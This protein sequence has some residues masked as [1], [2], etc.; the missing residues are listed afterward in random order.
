MPKTAR[1]RLCPFWITVDGT[2]TPVCKAM[3]NLAAQA[4]PIE[5]SDR[6]EKYKADEFDWDPRSG[7]ILTFTAFKLRDDQL[8]SAC[9]EKANRSAPIRGDESL[10]E[11]VVIAYCPKHGL[12]VVP[13]NHI[14]PRHTVIR[15]LLGRVGTEGPVFVE[16]LIDTEMLRRLNDSRL[17]RSIEFAI[18]TPSDV[19]ETENAS[20]KQALRM[21]HTLD[22]LR[23]EVKVS[24]GKHARR[25]STLSADTAK[26][27]M[28][29]LHSFTDTDVEKLKAG[30]KLDE[31]AKTEHLDL[32]GARVSTE[33][34]ID[35]LGRELD[36]VQCGRSVRGYLKT[37]L[38]EYGLE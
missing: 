13:Y 1:L 4:A 12:A 28:K 3:Q 38:S 36:R 21:L 20:V 29:V 33:V 27:L 32:L 18:D 26:T 8:P 37:L 23:V 30:V 9:S 10:G 16:P 17:V 25:D 34:P 15:S 7:G 35:V 11:P 19:R 24:L 6:S 22:G 2:I 31:G 5:F 14:G